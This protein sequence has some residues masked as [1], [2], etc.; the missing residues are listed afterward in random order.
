MFAGAPYVQNRV[1]VVGIVLDGGVASPAATERTNSVG[2]GPW[3]CVVRTAR[4][5]PGCSTAGSARC[6]DH[7]VAALAA[8]TS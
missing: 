5:V 2:L 1:T 8:G 4:L 6:K 7:M 3:G